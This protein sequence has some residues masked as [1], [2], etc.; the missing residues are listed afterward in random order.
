MKVFN[1][2]CNHVQ[3]CE[4]TGQMRTDGEEYGLCFWTQTELT[5]SSLSQQ[6][7]ESLI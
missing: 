4:G 5:A 1:S 6:N 2:C 7:P 3:E